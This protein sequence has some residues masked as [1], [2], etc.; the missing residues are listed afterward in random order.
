MVLGS[1]EVQM[2]LGCCDRAVEWEHTV[3]WSWGME[4][5]KTIQALGLEDWPTVQ[6][7]ATLLPRNLSRLS[8]DSDAVEVSLE[9]S[10]RLVTSMVLNATLQGVI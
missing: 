5:E 7:S 6:S 2:D 9:L 8:T 10:S 4:V 3:R 1:G